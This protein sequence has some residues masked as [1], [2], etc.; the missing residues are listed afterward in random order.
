V[1]QRTH[2]HLRNQRDVN[3]IHTVLIEGFS[4]RSDAYL[5]GRN[6]ANKVVVFPA[7][8]FKKGEYVNV[9]VDTCTGGT[10]IGKAVTE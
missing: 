6:T 7:E 4:K 8:Q 9:F 5:Q 3:K 2:S 1:K 10:L